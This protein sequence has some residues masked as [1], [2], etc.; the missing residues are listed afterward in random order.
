MKS[1]LT[2]IVEHP[3]QTET[4]RQATFDLFAGHRNAKG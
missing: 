2:F 3:S 4:N 1:F